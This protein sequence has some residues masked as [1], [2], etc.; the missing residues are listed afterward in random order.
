[1][2]TN[3]GIII[4][5][6]LSKIDPDLATPK[7]RSEMEQK[8]SQ[9]ARG[10]QDWQVVLEESIQTYLTKFQNFTS[11]IGN[12]DVLFESTFSPLSS[13]GKSFSKCGRC[14]RYMFLINLRPVRLHCRNCNET[15]PLPSTGGT[16]KLYK[17][18]VCPLDSFELVLWSTGSHGKGMAICP[19]CYNNPPFVGIPAGMGCNDCL[20]ANCLHSLV[21]NSIVNCPTEACEG[22]LVLDGTSAPRYKM[23]CNRCNLVSSFN[24]TVNDVQV[25]SDTLC[26]D[27]FAKKIKV[28]F[29]KKENRSDLVGCIVCDDELD[30]LL[31]TR[32]VRV[33]RFRGRGRGKRRGRGRGRGKSNEF[34]PVAGPD[35]PKTEAERGQRRGR[36]K[37]RRGR[38]SSEG[39]LSRPQERSMADFF[40][41]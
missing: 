29:V 24:D 15:Y 28:S 17:E 20:D 32:V 26:A 30:S 19:Q 37:G 39:D 9:I 6:G 1:M 34:V 18:L 36:G 11:K 16:I 4:I 31:E 2:P 35:R 41:F 40:S 5:H 13:S 3:L 38:G 33:G 21:S 7:L 8:I 22:V 25:K 14:R 27:C 23:G 10:E 12:M